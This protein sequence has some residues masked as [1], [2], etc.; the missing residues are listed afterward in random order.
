MLL[1][2]ELGFAKLGVDA[3][4]A[5]NLEF[6]DLLPAIMAGNRGRTATMARP[7]HGQRGR[8]NKTTYLPVPFY[9]QRTK[10]FL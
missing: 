8:K 9:I 4:S 5:M 3:Q 1:L 10:F 7:V 2:L 6:G